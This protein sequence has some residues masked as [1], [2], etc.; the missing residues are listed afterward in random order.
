MADI[1]HSGAIH[2]DLKLRGL[3]LAENLEVRID[4]WYVSGFVA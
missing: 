4:N 1:H 3:L 2:R